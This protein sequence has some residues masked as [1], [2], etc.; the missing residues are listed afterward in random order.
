MKRKLVVLTVILCFAIT[1]TAFAR[2][3]NR[4]NH[5]GYKNGYHNGSNSSG[6]RGGGHYKS[7]HHYKPRYYGHRRGYHNDG[8]EIA[9]GVIGGL[10]FG[11]A[12]MSS[13]L[14]PRA[15]VSGSPYTTY[16]PEVVVRQPRICLQDQLVNG[17]WQINKYDGHQVWVPFRYPVTRR[18][19]VPCY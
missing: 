10:L 6:Y 14:H 5:G 7:R 15:V 8:L 12:L 1:S 2:G 19:Q 18:V 17:E 13:A 9:A 16:Q 11:T 3:Y 4:G